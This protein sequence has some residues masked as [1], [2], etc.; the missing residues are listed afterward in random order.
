MFIS[1]IYSNNKYYLS[2][3]NAPLRNPKTSKVK[4]DKQNEHIKYGKC[5]MQGW[6]STM[7]TCNNI[8]KITHLIS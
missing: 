2:M 7:V 6:R 5:E 3:G 1:S 4:E 8:I